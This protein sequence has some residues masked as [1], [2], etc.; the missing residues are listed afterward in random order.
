MN[1]IIFEDE[2]LSADHLISLIHKT[3]PSVKVIAVAD[4]VRK[5]VEILKSNVSADLLFVDVHLADGLS[6]EIF[7]QVHTD[8]PVIF[9]TAYDE[10]A[11]KAF[12]LNSVDYLLKPV[13]I[14]ELSA[15]LSKMKKL[16]TPG[17]PLMIDNILQAYR[18]ITRQY[19][20]RFM[21]RMGENIFPVQAGD[22]VHFISDDPLVLLVS[23][24]GGR[25]PVDYTLDQLETLLDPMQFFRINRKV[26]L[27]I[28][29]IAKA[30]NYFN[31]RMKVSATHLADDAAIVSRER[32]S[33]FKEWL[34][35]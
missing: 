6:F 9:T 5:G 7:E 27:N 30:G 1:A 8:I 16:R 35:R 34:G 3:D 10:Y 31:S 11:L 17:S 25:Y 26:I 14:D 29:S 23:K 15:A 20:S 24:Q 33:G 32:V 21:V 22:I 18:D 28:D 19:K 2:K 13:G 12:T 4:T